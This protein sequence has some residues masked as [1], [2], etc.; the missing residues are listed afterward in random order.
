[1]NTTTFSTT[2][3]QKGQITLPKQLR[4]LLGL[5]T[6]QRVGIAVVDPK[7]NTMQVKPVPS[8]MSLAGKYKVKKPMDPVKT[9]EYMEKH[10][11]R[12]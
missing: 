3:T 9:R 6:G 12:I 1:M 11:Q 7:Q 10:Y 5:S 4:E 2:I 8:L